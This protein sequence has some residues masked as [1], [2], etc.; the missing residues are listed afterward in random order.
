[1]ESA[2]EGGRGEEEWKG[3]GGF[4]SGS[5]LPVPTVHTRLI[6]VGAPNMTVDRSISILLN[7]I[8][9]MRYQLTK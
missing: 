9:V 3:G 2:E 6:L 1:M 4:R 5:Y 7:L 8:A